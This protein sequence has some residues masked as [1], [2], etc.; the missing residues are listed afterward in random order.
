MVGKPY[1]RTLRLY[2][3][4]IEHWPIIDAHYH[5]VDL[6]DLPPHRFCNFVYAWLMGRID[7][8]KLEEVNYMLD[9]PL[10]G[11]EKKVTPMQQVDEGDSF[12][13]AMGALKGG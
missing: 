3:L 12:M 9:L 7:P 1:P 5:A 11:R 4:A 6:L 8:E 10:P 2:V 13:A